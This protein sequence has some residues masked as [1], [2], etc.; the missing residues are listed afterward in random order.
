[1]L[2]TS[3]PEGLL[4]TMVLFSVAVPLVEDAAARSTAELPDRVQ[5]VSVTV[6]PAEVLDAAA[7]AAGRVARQGGVGQRHR[8]RVLR[9]SRR[10]P[11]AELPDRVELVS[12][13]VPW[14]C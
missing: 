2:S 4:A 7:G 12:V 6:R 8:R 13:A 10:R 5:L 3:P 14:S 11:P 1:M 9:C